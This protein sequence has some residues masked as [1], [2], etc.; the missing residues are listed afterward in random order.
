MALDLSLSYLWHTFLI[1]FDLRCKQTFHW[2]CKFVFQADLWIGM[3]IERMHV[4]GVR[5]LN[6]F[7]AY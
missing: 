2:L 5:A 4:H 7:N 6:S 1:V 3:Y